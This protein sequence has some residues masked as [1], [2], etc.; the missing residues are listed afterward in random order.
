MSNWIFEDCTWDDDDVWIDAGQ[1]RD[2]CSVPLPD[3]TQI[4]SFAF[5][6]DG[7]D[8]YVLRLGDNETLV[9]DL[10]TGS[11]ASWDSQGR[12]VWRANSG[13]NWAA[14]LG[15]LD[16]NAPATNVLLGDDTFS[17]LWTLTTDLAADEGPFQGDTLRKFSRA[18]TGGLPFRSRTSPRCNAVT[19]TASIGDPGMT[20]TSIQL[21]ISDNNGA[22]YRN[23]GTVNVQPQNFNKEIRWRSLGLMKAPGRLFEIIDSGATV[24]ID[25]LDADVGDIRGDEN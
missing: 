11:W 19:L 12:N 25:G 15:S 6:L 7:H 14:V 20:S 21:R 24:R 5:S 9:Y 13:F 3:Y 17:T 4:A 1:W 16:P 23:I 8:F 18:I 10:T 2:D 22:S